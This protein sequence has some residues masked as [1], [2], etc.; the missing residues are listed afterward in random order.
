MRDNQLGDAGSL[1]SSRSSCAAEPE[2]L[3]LCAEQQLLGAFVP[4]LEEL[5]TTPVY[6]LPLFSVQLG[7][8]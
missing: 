4:L 3:C 2:D 8:L 7:I 5:S 1:W 6:R